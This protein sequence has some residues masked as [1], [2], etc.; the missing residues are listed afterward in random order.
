MCR[1]WIKGIQILIG[2]SL[3]GFD[4]I[5]LSLITMVLVNCFFPNNHCGFSV[6][7]VPGLL[8]EQEADPSSTMSY[9]EYSFAL[10]PA[11]L[12]SC[13]SLWI[14]ADCILIKMKDTEAKKRK[15]VK[16]VLRIEQLEIFIILLAKCLLLY[17]LMMTTGVHLTWYVIVH[18]YK[19]INFIFFI[20][21]F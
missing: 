21:P 5:K 17:V 13:S 1:T 2:L 10:L 11:F 12:V 4:Y 7:S 18:S 16:M 20:A 9:L 3:K 19:R 15:Q 8:S 14:L 6:P